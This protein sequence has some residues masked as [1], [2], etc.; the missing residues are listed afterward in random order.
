MARDTLGIALG[1]GPVYEDSTYKYIGESE[2]GVLLTDSRW[3]ISRINKTTNRV[4]WANVIKNVAGF[5]NVFTDLATV[6][7]LSYS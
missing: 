1:I 4:E 2:P 6:A 5:N 7:A 3:R